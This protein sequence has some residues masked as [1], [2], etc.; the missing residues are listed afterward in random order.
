MPS[1][2]STSPEGLISDIKKQQLSSGGAPVHLWDPPFLGDLDLRISRSGEWFYEE[3]PISRIQ[4]VKLFSTVLKRE[5]DNYY[6]VTPVEKWRISVEDA[7]FV[8]VLL[9]PE[10]AGEAQ[11]LVFN[12]NVG[13]EVV[14]GPNNPIR[15]EYDPV[16][17]EPK[18]YIFVRDRL[19]ALISRN[20]FYQLVELAEQRVMEGN[21]VL[22]VNSGGE[23]F[24]LGEL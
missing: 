10:G 13:E 5:E 16:T 20:V 8:A 19:E 15:V 21:E 12:T 9:E 3:S 18:P 22:G 1:D 24:S 11:S 6:L 2:K 4:I 23:F 17:G 7:P 14:A